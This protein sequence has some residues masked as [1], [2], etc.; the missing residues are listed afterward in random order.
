MSEALEHV[1]G[2]RKGVRGVINTARN[3][4]RSVYDLMVRIDQELKLLEAEIKNELEE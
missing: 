2:I 1:A 3:H 4:D